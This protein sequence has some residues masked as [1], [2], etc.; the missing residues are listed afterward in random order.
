MR[1]FS[2]SESSSDYPN[3]FKQPE[4]TCLKA[5]EVKH[6]LVIH[7]VVGTFNPA[8]QLTESR[9]LL[10][11]FKELSLS[12]LEDNLEKNKT[13]MDFTKIRFLVPYSEDNWNYIKK[14][15]KTNEENKNE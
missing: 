12:E 5:G 2:A 8:L 14:Y 7:L 9:E 6:L 3:Q 10:I 13:W 1:L 15:F 11:V 4:Y